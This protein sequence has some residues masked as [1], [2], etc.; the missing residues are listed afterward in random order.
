MG[1]SRDWVEMEKEKVHLLELLSKLPD[2]RRRAGRR[3]RL[4]DIL[5][6][7]LLAVLCGADDWKSIETFGVIR[8]DWLVELLDLK[9]GVP[10]DDTY[11]R[12]FIRIDSKKFEELFIDWTRSLSGSLGG[13]VAIDGK[14]LRRSHDGADSPLHLVS[15]WAGEHRLVLGQQKCKGKE[16]EAGA[17][18]RL[19][20]VFCLEGT[21]VSIDAAGTQ[22][23]IARQI[24]EA[25]GD[26]LL[27]LKK[28][29]PNLLEEGADL[30][31]V[32][33]SEKHV[34]VN[35]DHGRIETRTC[36]L[37]R[38]T[39]WLDGH[40]KW[41]DLNSLIRIEAT[42]ETAKGVQRQVRYYISS[43][44][45]S[46]ETFNHAV[47]NHWGIENSLHWTL[48]MVFREDECRKRKGN[49]AE[50]FAIIRRYALNLLKKDQQTKLG[51]KNRRLMAGWDDNYLWKILAGISAD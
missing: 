40:A 31:R 30:F 36:S 20:G 18:K 47:R 15:A 32:L 46:A 29:Q 12:L 51:L 35:G 39:D 17:I 44:Q 5:T 11:R 8:Q 4:E 7:A 43:L 9:H 28:N 26:Y 19:L 41:P 3:H 25:K 34:M 24:V 49:E 42:R 45:A 10:S 22:P 38:G 37:I 50:N 6:I 23:A 2:P 27:A 16:N 13:H 48:D 21:L 14:A 33:E 1:E